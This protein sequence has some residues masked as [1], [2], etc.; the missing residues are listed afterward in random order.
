MYILLIFFFKSKLNAAVYITLVHNFMANME[1]FYDALVLLAI[2]S[3]SLMSILYVSFLTM[4]HYNKSH[5][6]LCSKLTEKPLFFALR[7]PHLFTSFFPSFHK[8]LVSKLS[9]YITNKTADVGHHDVLE[10]LIPF[11]Q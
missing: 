2:F 3:V 8:N 1:Y 9:Q 11:D 5:V 4:K 10:L 7:C 6:L